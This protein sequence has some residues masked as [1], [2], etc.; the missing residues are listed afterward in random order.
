MYA[1]IYRIQR[2]EKKSLMF[3]HPIALLEAKLTI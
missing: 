2:Y 1:K 3:N